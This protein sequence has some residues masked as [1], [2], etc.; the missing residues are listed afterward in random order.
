MSRARRLNR[1]IRRAVERQLEETASKQSPLRGRIV[2]ILV[3]VIGIPG[4]LAAL[5]TLLPRVTPT[6]SDPVD[7]DDPFSASVTITN[8]GLI[9]LREVDPGIGLGEFITKG[10]SPHDPNFKPLY[11]PH[12]HNISWG[13]HDLGLD[14]KFTFALNDV[15]ETQEKGGLDYADIA[16]TVDYRIPV[17]RWKQEKIFPMI[18]R[19]QT[20]GRFYWYAKPL[21]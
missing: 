19:K 12:Y 8:T 1:T 10:G 7:P 11:W 20:N 3:F 4:V 2:K 17:L 21:D 15:W 14:Q 13:I 9:P 18:A 16:I 5:L 6:V